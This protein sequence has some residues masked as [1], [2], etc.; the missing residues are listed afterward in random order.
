[1]ALSDVYQLRDIQ[2]A[3]ADDPENV[4]FFEKLDPAGTAEDCIDAFLTTLMPSIRAIQAQSVQHVELN[5]QSL[6][7]LADFATRSVTLAGLAGNTDV[8]PAFVAVGYTLKPATRA[9]RP[10]SKRFIGVLEAV[11]TNGKITEPTFVAAVEALRVK[12]DDN[13]VGTLSEYQPVIVK[14]IKT[15]VPDTQ[16]QKYK[17][18]LPKAG[19]PL[20]LGLIKQ[21]LSNPDVT[22]QDSRE[23]Y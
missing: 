1:V 10:G 18:T 22:H 20:V 3:G 4:W 14:R 5:C 9:V 19:D 23:H 17:Y 15:A 13:I 11:V 12:L 16:P 6:G 21:A 8:M 2:S 7:D